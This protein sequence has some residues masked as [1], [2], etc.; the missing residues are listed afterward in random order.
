VEKEGR[1]G[2]CL[3]NCHCSCGYLSA[4]SLQLGK[5][6]AAMREEEERP[7]ND[8]RLEESRGGRGGKDTS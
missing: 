5:N 7:L 3:C 4:L 2:E 1:E 6:H 8:G